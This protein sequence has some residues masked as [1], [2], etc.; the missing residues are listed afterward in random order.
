MMPQQTN[1]NTLMDYQDAYAKAGRQPIKLPDGEYNVR[2]TDAWFQ[3]EHY[4]ESDG[5]FISTY[6][7]LNLEVMQGDL[8]GSLTRTF[9]TLRR[10][11][12]QV[13]PESVEWFRRDLATLGVFTDSI[14]EVPNLVPT[15]VGKWV[16]IEV[17][18]NGKYQNIRLKRLIS[19]PP[20]AQQQS[21]PQQPQQ[22]QQQTTQPQAQPQQP[23]S[24][25]QG[26]IPGQPHP[27]NGQQFGGSTDF[28]TFDDN[29]IPF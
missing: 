24:V 12:G 23:Y 9:L 7:G 18:T 16:Q 28:D 25:Q 14:V 10:D 29:N 19:A 5:R 22:S 11:Y 21:Q 15:V 20:Q 2:I 6:V 4:R 17:T 27:N 1:R 26:H 3:Y 13:V 8:A